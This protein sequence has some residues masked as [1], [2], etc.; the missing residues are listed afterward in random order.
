MYKNVFHNSTLFCSF[1]AGTDHGLLPIGLCIMTS[2]NFQ[3]VIGIDINAK[4]LQTARQNI[5]AV[6]MGNTTALNKIQLRQGYGIDPLKR[7]DGISVVSIAGMGVH[8]IISILKK[9]IHIQTELGIKRVVIQPAGSRACDMTRLRSFLHPAWKITNESLVLIKRR[10][11]VTF[12]CEAAAGASD[13][14]KSEILPGVGGRLPFVAGE[15]LVAGYG[16]NLSSSD[17]LKLS[18]WAHERKCL[19]VALSHQRAWGGREEKG[20]CLEMEYESSIITD[21]L[22]QFD[23][24]LS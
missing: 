3:G 5:K 9:T 21:V 2:S 6:E 19:D 23:A 16:Q 20:R 14:V 18:Y 17:Q 24:R 11:Y 10:F 8:S 4:P 15:H 1:L 12:N 13:D 22:A 7:S